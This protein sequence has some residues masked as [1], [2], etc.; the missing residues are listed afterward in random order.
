MTLSIEQISTADDIAAAS[1][2]VRA[3][4]TW[5]ISLDPDAKDAPTFRDLENELASL[6]G[7]FGPP[8][9]C[10]LLARHEGRPVGCVCGAWRR[11]GR[12]KAHVCKP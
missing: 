5:A 1:N 12:I 6:P 11:R 10:F 7:I 3:L 2:L 4:M 9:G 8:S